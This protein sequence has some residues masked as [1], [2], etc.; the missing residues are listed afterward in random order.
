M[1]KKFYIQLVKLSALI[2]LANI[3]FLIYSGFTGAA[4]PGRLGLACF[5]LFAASLVIF[6]SA[7]LFEPFFQERTEI[8]PTL[9]RQIASLEAAHQQP[10]IEAETRRAAIAEQQHRLE[11][12]WWVNRQRF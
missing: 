10:A 8:G 1:F 7:Y 2:I 6:F 11:T 12:A 3:S 9:L 4:I 5:L